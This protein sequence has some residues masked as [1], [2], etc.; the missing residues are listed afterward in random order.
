MNPTNLEI[1]ERPRIYK[2][3]TPA[4]LLFAAAVLYRVALGLF[5]SGDSWMPNFAPVAAIA[6]CGPLIFPR[7]LAIALP[8]AILL[9]SDLVLNWHYGV[10]SASLEMAARYAAL[11]P[12]AI[13]G[14]WLSGRRRAGEFLLASAIG[15]TL[16]YLVTNSVSWATAP[17]YAK[18]VAGWWQAL[19]VGLP[20]Y[21]PTWMFFRNSLVSDAIF[22]FLFV[23]CLAWAG[24][25]AGPSRVPAMSVPAECPSRV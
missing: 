11:L 15:S 24:R 20:G 4:I 23:A 3:M 10:G 19:T 6:L 22:T 9:A 21:P 13:A 17:G 8:L 5:G 14:S 16:F 12:L 18:T 25:C 2:T 1:S 7:R